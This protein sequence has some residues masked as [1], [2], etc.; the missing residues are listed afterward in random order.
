MDEKALKA[1]FQKYSRKRISIVMDARN[2]RKQI[3]G[4][5]REDGLAD[6]LEFDH[7][8]EAWEK[9]KLATTS[10]LVFSVER[11]E[12]MEFL[13][14]LIDS[15]RFK[16]A[17]MVV[18]TN[19]VKEHPKHF[20]TADAI[21]QWAETPVNGFKVEQALISLFQ[22]GVAGKSKVL[23]ESKSLEYYQRGVDALEDERYEEA[24]EFFR[25]AIKES[26]D[27]FEAYVKMAETLIALGD[28]E[29]ALR[30]ISKAETLMPD[31]PKTLY[32]KAMIACETLPKE[33]ALKV[34]ELAVSKKQTDLMFVI[35]IGNL[36]LK[37]GW[38]D[39]SLTFFETAQNID[40]ELI[41]VYNRMGIAQSRAGRYDKALEM[42]E[43]ALNIDEADA[44]VHFN[45]GMMWNRKGE[46]KKALDSFKKAAQIDPHMQESRDMIAK[47]ESV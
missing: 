9:L 11:A 24:K 21:I 35:D 20:T 4:V 39:E 23:D 43:R 8:D 31:H 12:G 37:K 29:A 36:A 30:V 44:G 10:V 13:R 1:L 40:P 6:I 46:G 7:C 45:I 16:T 5:L 15:T 41:H 32:L 14:R 27:F 17:P 28:Y 34:L 38:V 19:K 26:P 25:Q 22:R 18:F 33:K 47:L 2:D 3:K 42:Y